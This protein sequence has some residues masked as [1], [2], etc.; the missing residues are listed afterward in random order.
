MPDEATDATAG[1]VRPRRK[2]EFVNDPWTLTSQVKRILPDEF[3]HKL[4]DGALRVI[5]DRDNPIRLNLFSAA[6]RELL[7]HVLQGLAPD[8]EIRKCSWFQ[9]EGPAGRPTRRQR[10]I[11]LAQGGLS[12]ETVGPLGGAIAAK[13]H[14]D[15]LTVMDGLNKYTHVRPGTVIDDQPQIEAFAS[16]SFK[17]VDD[18]FYPVKATRALIANAMTRRYAEPFDRFVRQ[19][20]AAAPELQNRSDL[21]P[22]YLESIDVLAID[23]AHVWLRVEGSLSDSVRFQLE[24]RAPVDNL[25]AVELISRLVG[26]GEFPPGED[27]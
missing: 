8:D 18:L 17:A 11:Y 6:I 3:C 14:A 27:G 10:A 7:T 22:L 13:A 19:A 26:E 1:P 4:I 2:F 16:A 21:E 24:L 5:A 23:A 20:L 25:G 12:D 9:P 15:I